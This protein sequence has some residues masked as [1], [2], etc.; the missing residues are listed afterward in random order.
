MNQVEAKESSSNAYTSESEDIRH[1]LSFSLI[2]NV[3]SEQIENNVMDTSDHLE[4]IRDKMRLNQIAYE[5]NEPLLDELKKSS[6]LFFDD[7]FSKL[8]RKLNIEDSSLIL[9]EDDFA[10][11][12]SYSQTL[13]NFMIL[14]KEEHL[15]NFFT[16]KIKDNLSHYVKAYKKDINKKDFMVATLRKRYKNFDDVAVIYKVEDII[17]SCVDD[18]IFATDFLD[19]VF[20]GET[21]RIDYPI[22]TEILSAVATNNFITLYFWEILSE[23]NRHLFKIQHRVT[24]NMANFF[25]KKEK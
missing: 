10:K 3:L 22:L 23:D 1:S 16:R 17:L 2:G 11:I 21:D 5:T 7:I 24:E 14:D 4:L 15:V 20:D 12:K 18:E 6:S 9:H 25:D 8:L 19:S 13:Y